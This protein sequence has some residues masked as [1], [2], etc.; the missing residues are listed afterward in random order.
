MSAHIARSTAATPLRRARSRKGV[1]LHT[2]TELA[3][4]KPVIAWRRADR[5]KP[6]RLQRPDGG[7]VAG[8]DAVELV[9][10]ADAELHEDLAQVVLDRAG[11]DEQPGA[12]LRV[13][14][15]VAG[16]PRDPGLLGGQLTGGLDGALAGGLAR[17][18]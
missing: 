14:E 18:L 10:G 8:Q 1:V 5:D 7:R 17:R 6:R 13:R 12:D 3:G 9:A 2:K 15:A 11:A 16:Q 4:Q